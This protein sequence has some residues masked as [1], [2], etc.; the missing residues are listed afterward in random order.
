MKL[1]NQAIRS[2][3][4]HQL[5]EIAD[6]A[7]V[8]G[9]QRATPPQHQPQQ[10][11]PSSRRSATGLQVQQRQNGSALPRQSSAGGS[12]KALSATPIW[13]LKD[14][15]EEIRE[16]EQRRRESGVTR[17][18]KPNL[19]EKFAQLLTPKSKGWTPQKAEAP[20]YTIEGLVSVKHQ[21]LPDS[22]R[23][24]HRATRQALGE[25][26]VGGVGLNDVLKEL[27]RRGVT[28]KPP[29]DKDGVLNI[30]ESD[31]VAGRNG[32]HAKLRPG[33]GKYLQDRQDQIAGIRVN[34][35]RSVDL[36]YVSM[37][38]GFVESAGPIRAN[39]FYVKE[40][41][42]VGDV[43]VEE[44]I[45]AG[46]IQSR[47]NITARDIVTDECTVYG[48]IN[49]AETLKFTAG[50]TESKQ[51]QLVTGNVQCG[52]ITS[53]DDCQ[54]E[55]GD[56]LVRGNCRVPQLKT[57]DLSVGWELQHAKG[58]YVTGKANITKLSKTIDAE[59]E[60]QGKALQQ[61]VDQ[62][63]DMRKQMREEDVIKKIKA[64][65]N[66]AGK[67]GAQTIEWTDA[68]METDAYKE[69]VLGET[70]TDDTQKTD[71]R[72]KRSNKVVRSNA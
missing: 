26:I 27:E 49:C 47:G 1:K 69:H 52:N 3:T 41:H 37:P 21:P 63:R 55:V 72:G 33:I 4:T 40:L 68:E 43:T 13:E 53:E 31:L 46:E 60:F 25:K 17:G 12:K 14:R 5:K 65:T 70:P 61:Y 28:Y 7:Y 24:I 11:V 58:L 23:N 67:D 42:T 39:Y 48:N 44:F 35:T 2:L 22:D 20:G 59:A 45:H 64:A 10:A 51:L 71:Q 38:H 8:R 57:K 6:L 54:V 50:S 62:L 9:L 30:E 66:Q 19:F 18:R 16:K 36:G 32:E 29:I 34:T 56:L 15:A